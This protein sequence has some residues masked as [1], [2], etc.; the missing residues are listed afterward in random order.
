MPKIYY[1]NYKIRGTAKWVKR[2]SKRFL[3]MRCQ[4]EYDG[5]G[6]VKPGEHI[7]MTCSN[8]QEEILTRKSI[9]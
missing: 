7:S 3:H 8:C 9:T 6:D 4:M 5:K 1:E 2:D